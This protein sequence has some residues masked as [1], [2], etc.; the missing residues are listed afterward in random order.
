MWGGGSG[1]EGEGVAE[2]GYVSLLVSYREQGLE[3]AGGRG[4][5]GEREK[6]GKGR[7]RGRKKKMGR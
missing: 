3:W 5:G 2:R 4:E 7:R 1:R 6:K